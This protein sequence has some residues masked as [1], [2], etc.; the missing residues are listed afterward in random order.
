MPI[1]NKS[2]RTGIYS[3]NVDITKKI[4]LYCIPRLL[5]YIIPPFAAVILS[6]IIRAIGVIAAAEFILNYIVIP[7]FI[8]CGVLINIKTVDIIKRSFPRTQKDGHKVLSRII[9]SSLLSFAALVIT[10]IISL[11]LYGIFPYD[12]PAASY[13]RDMMYISPYAI[14][15]FFMT[16]LILIFTFSQIAVASYFIGH[17]KQTKFT[18]T[19]SCLV[20]F[21]IYV[22]LLILFVLSYFAATFVDIIAL[23]NIQIVN[24][25]FNSSILCSFIT[26]DL[27]A[28]PCSLIM[29]FITYKSLNTSKKEL[30]RK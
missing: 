22:A 11:L 30:H 4:Y 15:I 20:F 23:E 18:F 12:F 8:F 17:K 3:A 6:L 10:I 5:L 24:T 14:T 16:L 7:L 25:I 27:I 13:L 28:L 2:N 1:L 9:S 19:K 21:L 26:F 29:Y